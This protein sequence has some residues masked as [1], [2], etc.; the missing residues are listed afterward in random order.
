MIF[1]RAGRILKNKKNEHAYPD[2][3]HERYVAGAS[4]WDPSFWESGSP[5]SG[6]RLP[7]VSAVVAPLRVS[8][9][10][11]AWNIQLPSARLSSPKYL[12][13]GG[14]LFTKNIIRGDS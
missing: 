12:R 4:P 6:Y 11:A 9:P 7:A 1:I 10:Q 3:L 8:N 2:A 13:G 14:A 5:S